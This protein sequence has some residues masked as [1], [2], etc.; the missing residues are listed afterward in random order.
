MKLLKRDTDICKRIAADEGLPVSEV[1]KAV[2]SYFDS[3]LSQAR[4]LPFDN[5]RRIY[6]REAFDQYPFCVNIPY[7][8]RLGTFYSL[9]L[10]WRAQESKEQELVRRSVAKREHTRPMV[11][12][13]ARRALAGEKVDGSFLKARLPKDKYTTVWLVDKDSKKKAARQMIVNNNT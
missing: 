12:E 2:V 13:A 6:S 11:E 3:I 7:L 8:G 9:Y 4:K 10:K 5:A 1:R